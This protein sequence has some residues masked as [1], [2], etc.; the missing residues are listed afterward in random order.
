MKYP[1]LI[2]MA[3]FGMAYMGCAEVDEAA[4]SQT[5]D[6]RCEVTV[7][8]ELPE[9]QVVTRSPNAADEQRIADLNLYVFGPESKHFY[10]SPETVPALTLPPGSYR[11]YA[12]ANMGRNLGSL[13]AGELESC[14]YAVTSP[15]EVGG[16][17]LLAMSGS[18]EFTVTEDTEVCLT[19]TRLTAK[20]RFD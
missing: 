5:Q 13:S 8:F 3:L 4:I 18:T 6:V 17:G 7:T 19:L 2:L 10:V 16:N 14:T 9:T 20:V 15:A 1:H 12:V 11:L